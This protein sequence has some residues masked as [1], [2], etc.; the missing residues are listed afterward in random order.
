[1]SQLTVSV[2]LMALTAG[3]ASA[4]I[5]QDFEAPG[6]AGSAAGTNLTTPNQGS[7]YVPVTNPVSADYK[8]FKYAG[9]A[10]GF[11]ANPAG[12]DQFI[13]G[14]SALPV[15]T[16][17]RA[18]HPA[19]FDLTKKYVATFELTAKFSGTLPS[20]AN[21]GSFSLQPSAAPA[22]RFWQTL[23][24]WM[25][26]T[27]ATS[28]AVRYLPFNAAGTQAAAPGLTPGPEWENLDPANWYRIETKWD[29][30]TN[31]ITEVSITNLTTNVKTTAQLTGYY[32]AGGM[33]STLPAPTDVR[34]FAGGKDGNTMAWDNLSVVEDAPVCYSDC[35][36]SGGLNIDDFICFQTFFALGDPFADCD[37]S[38]GLNIDDFIC[39]QTF[40]ALGC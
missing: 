28:F 38:G 36:S 18:Q 16:F 4:Q 29:F 5:N 11:P 34:F 39:F 2:L 21:L 27:T 22:T 3:T 32:L 1:M 14:V 35:D 37:S 13:A 25:S 6:I 33:N 31:L 30:A 9:N 19:S 12:G 8:V 23:H 17:A 40:F 24:N 26:D 20:A 15:N 10:L 7:W